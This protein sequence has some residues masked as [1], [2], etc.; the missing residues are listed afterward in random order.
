MI[1]L[2]SIYRLLGAAI[3]VLMVFVANAQVTLPP[4][5]LLN[6]QWQTGINRHYDHSATVPGITGDPTKIASGK[7]WYKKEITLPG[8]N[9]EQAILELKGA[10]FLPEVY[11][12][13]KLISK[14]N[15]GMAPTF[16][17]LV[18]PDVRPGNKVLI[19]VALASLKDVPITDASYIPPPDQ[20]R[21]NVSSCLW[22]DV[23]IHF[24]G[25]A[26]IIDA[27]PDVDFNR[28]HVSFK[29]NIAANAALEE[30]NVVI[31]ITDKCL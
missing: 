6:G 31:K 16:H 21:S 27:L 24:A 7:R 8:G 18:G 14:S 5:M 20:W 30:Q 4:D 28:H 19:E 2:I 23:V 17:P 9:W 11:V 29:F 1:R 10:R 3:G 22:D 26:R 12:N 15:G 25:N 13:G